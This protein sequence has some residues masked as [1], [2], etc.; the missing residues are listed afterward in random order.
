MTA[1]EGVPPTETRIECEGIYLGGL[2]T[3]G[4]ETYVS[5][6]CDGLS[7]RFGLI[8]PAV[9]LYIDPQQD[10]ASI[11]MSFPREEEPEGT[12]SD[13]ESGSVELMVNP[14]GTVVGT[15]EAAFGSATL[16]GVFNSA[17][18]PGNYP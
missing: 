18:D 7:L 11:R 4:V 12:A 5:D 3:E 8:G 2:C 15:F 16:R 9:L 6:H 1:Y 14:D 10:L 13:A 17:Y